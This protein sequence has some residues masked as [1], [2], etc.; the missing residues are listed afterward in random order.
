MFVSI[1]FK[2]SDWELDKF[3]SE[4]VRR[5][6]EI[7]GLCKC[8]FGKLRVFEMELNTLSA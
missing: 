5:E 4:L 2:N 8:T 1:M 3:R 6:S 7:V